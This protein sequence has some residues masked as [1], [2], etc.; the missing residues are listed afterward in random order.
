MN[1]YA[2][3]HDLGKLLERV[4][5]VLPAGTV[6][7]GRVGGVFLRFKKCKGVVALLGTCFSPRV[8]VDSISRTMGGTVD[9]IGAI[10]S[11]G[12]FL[13]TLESG[14]ELAKHL[15]ASA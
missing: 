5:H 11:T 13:P 9:A 2:S 8:P 15:E 14:R 6:I 10:D 3:M 1:T 7:R 12:F 4:L